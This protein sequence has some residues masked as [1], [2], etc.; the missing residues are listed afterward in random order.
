MSIAEQTRL[1]ELKERVSQLEK[2]VRELLLWKSAMSTPTEP[3]PNTLHLP[4]K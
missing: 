1:T 4:R 3:P 2:E